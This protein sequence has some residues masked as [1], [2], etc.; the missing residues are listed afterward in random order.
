MNIKFFLSERIRVPV[1][2]KSQQQQEQKQAQKISPASATD[3]SPLVYTNPQFEQQQQHQE[4]VPSSFSSSQQQRQNHIT[5]PISSI[6][7][8]SKKKQAPAAPFAAET[9]SASSLFEKH[10]RMAPSNATGSI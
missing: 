3:H 2:Q 6:I 9:F 4:P 1:S 8:S 7:N 10:R 5:S